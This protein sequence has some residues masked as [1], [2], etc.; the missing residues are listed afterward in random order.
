VCQSVRLEKHSHKHQEF[1][2]YCK[3]LRSHIA[4][5][6]SELTHRLLL[7]NE[8]FPKV[9]YRRFTCLTSDVFNVVYFMSL[10]VK[11]VIWKYF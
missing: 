3:E 7:R 11:T 1:V 4:Q 6:E 9:H 10:T 2:Q 5:M 8:A